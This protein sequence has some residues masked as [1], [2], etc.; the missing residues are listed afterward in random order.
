[1]PK[2]NLTDQAVR[3]FSAGSYWDA[4]LSGFG[5]RVSPNGGKTFV[6][7]VASGRRKSLGRYPLI[8]LAQARAEATRLLAEKT[9]GH[10]RPTRTAFDDAKSDFLEDCARKNRP[11]TVSDYKRLLGIHYSFGRKSV[12]DITPYE[13]IRRLN[14]LGDTPAE[15]YHAYAVGSTFFRWCRRQQLIEK[16]PMEAMKVPPPNNSRERVLTETEL[17]KVL[18]VTQQGVSN[19]DA[20]VQ[21]LILT[22]QRKSEIGSLRWSWID[23]VEKVITLPSALTK[24]RREHRFPIGDMTLKVLASVPRWKDNPYVFPASRTGIKGKPATTTFNGWSKAKAALDKKLKF[25][26][27]TLHDLRRT[28]RTNWAELA[29]PREVAEKYINHVSGVHSGVNAIYDRH[30]YQGEMRSAVSRWEAR[31]Q[32]QVKA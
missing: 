1:M 26:H 25:A 16:N 11:R 22:G 32:A 31:L 4:K 12:A 7:L 28:L 3:N 2:L 23:P 15:K 30:S 9:L 17:T 18:R 10:I 13:I 19:Y 14:L 27:W 5:I 24:N 6:L 21:L 29:V 20:I 8:T